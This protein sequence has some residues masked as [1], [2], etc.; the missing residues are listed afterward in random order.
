[1]GDTIPSSG[2]GVPGNDP[3]T[4]IVMDPVRLRDLVEYDAPQS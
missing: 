3:I 4:Q 1:M 2:V